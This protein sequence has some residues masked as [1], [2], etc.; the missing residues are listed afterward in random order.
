MLLNL[1]RGILPPLKTWED[2]SHIYI[3]LIR[4]LFSHLIA[5]AA[6]LNNKAFHMELCSWFSQESAF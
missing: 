4:V 3:H 2:L 1:C 5:M 6:A